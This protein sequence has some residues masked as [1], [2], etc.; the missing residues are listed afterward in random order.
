MKVGAYCSLNSFLELRND[1]EAFPSCMASGLFID[2]DN[3]KNDHDDSDYHDRRRTQRSTIQHLC[4]VEGQDCSSF[5]SY[6]CLFSQS[7]PF[8]STMRGTSL[9]GYK[10]TP[11]ILSEGNLRI[12]LGTLDWKYSMNCSDF[13]AMC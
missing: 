4:D 8:H 7:S 1:V 3:G 10:N 5:F 13:V 2:D 11:P 6:W 12:G 9:T